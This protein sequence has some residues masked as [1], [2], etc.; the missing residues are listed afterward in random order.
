MEKEENANRLRI[1][2]SLASCGRS[3]C[4]S[5][6][7]KME[8]VKKGDNTARESVSSIFSLAVFRVAPK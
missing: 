2:L 7:R 5:V 1:L 6:V 3:V 4:W 8:S